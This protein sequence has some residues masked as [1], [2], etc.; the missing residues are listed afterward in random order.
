MKKIIKKMS[1]L[2]LSIFCVFVSL[3]V[4]E[5]VLRIWGPPQIRLVG[6]KLLLK[7]NITTKNSCYFDSDK[8]KK[9]IVVTKNSLG[10]RGPEPPENFYKH[11]SLVAVGGSTTECIFITEGKTW[12]DYLQSN[13]LTYF[14]DIW[15]N[16]AGIDGHSTYGHI[17]L[18]RQYVGKLRPD[19]VLFLVGINDMAVEGES[20]QDKQQISEENVIGKSIIQKIRDNSM[21]LAF[22]KFQK[23]KKIGHDMF[24]MK[25]TIKEYNSIVNYKVLGASTDYDA[26]TSQDLERI[27]NN[28]MAYRN[29]LERLVLLTKS[30]SIHPI[31]VTQP[32]VYGFGVD[33]VTGIDL[34]NIP[35]VEFTEPGVTRSGKDKWMILQK[36]NEV[37]REVSSEFGIP[38]IDLAMEMPKST[39]YFYDY[40][41]F[42]E[43]GAQKVGE[44]VTKNLIKIL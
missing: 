32:A 10:F 39:K 1:V 3:L 7:K 22:Y 5:V 2:F 40:I 27:N 8:I 26:V 17:E 4:V 6:T 38:L 44:I 20:I 34:G 29:R 12:T 13:L 28:L 36:Y 41:H 19:Y 15:I 31:L 35:I 16:N 14:P 11:L 42:T 24:T 33:D 25:T 37:T 9:N 30:Y 23:D 18:M 43:E 21:I